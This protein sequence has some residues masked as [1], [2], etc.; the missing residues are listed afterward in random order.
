M[1]IALFLVL[2]RFCCQLSGV[3]ATSVAGSVLLARSWVFAK[4]KYWMVINLVILLLSLVT[5]ATANAIKPMITA[6]D[7]Y[8][9]ALSN[10]GG[11]KC[12]GLNYD[13]QLGDGTGLS[14]STALNVVGLTS[15][16]EAITTGS[17]HACALSVGGGVK[18]W[19]RGY[20]G[21]LGNNS[22]GVSLLPV[23]VTGLGSGVLAIAAGDAHTCALTTAGGV[24]CWGSNANG[25]LGDGSTAV[26]YVPVNVTGLTSG[27][28]AIATGLFHT[29]AL[30][31]TGGVKCWG[32]N[33]DG[34][35]GDGSTVNRL[36]PVNV[37]GLTSGVSTISA[38]QHTCAISSNGGAKCWG[39]NFH[40]N[41]GNGSTVGSLT[42]V[43]VTGMT[44]GVNAISTG[45]YSSCAV[46][47]SGSAKCWGLN[48]GGELGD[49][50]AI[51]RSTPVNVAGLT[52]GV[53]SIGLGHDHACALTSYG[54]VKCWGNNYL[55]QLGDGT[56][57]N[58]LTPVDVV[59]L[60]LNTI[61]PFGITLV[62][63]GASPLVTGSQGHLAPWVASMGD[64]VNARMGGSVPIIKLTVQKNALGQIVVSSD[65]TL[66]I[67]STN[68][69]AII[70]V[71]WST[72]SEPLCAN[73]SVQLRTSTGSVAN[74]LFQYFQSD[75]PSTLKLPWHMIGH[76]RGGSMVNA[77]ATA[78]STRGLWTN[79]VTFLDYH[80]VTGCPDY[81]P[82]V[83]GGVL[84]ADS[85]YE[86]YFSTFPNGSSVPGTF[87]K[88]LNGILPW[89]LTVVGFS[90]L[91]HTL[92][93]TY[94]HGTIDPFATGDGDGQSID[95]AWYS[96]SDRMLG[97][98]Y[99]REASQQSVS[100]VLAYPTEGLTEEISGGMGARIQSYA[101]VLALA[102]LPAVD[103]QDL[104]NNSAAVLSAF[105]PN[106]IIANSVISKSYTVGV[107]TYI[108]VTSQHRTGGYTLK[109]ELDD[110]LNPFNATAPGCTAVID[111]RTIAAS[112][113]SFRDTQIPWTPLAQNA[114][115]CFIRAT[116]TA[117]NSAGLERYSY[118]SQAITIRSAPV[119]SS[120]PSAPSVG[121]VVAGDGK[122]TVPFTANAIGT[123]SLIEYTAVCSS[124][125]FFNDWVY[126]TATT[127]PVVVE[128]LI[129]GT[130]YSCGVKTSSTAGVSE[131]SSVS[132]SVTPVGIPDLI[133]TSVTSPTTG[134]AGGFINVSVTFK[135]QGTA[136]AGSFFSRFLLST[137]ST[138]STSDI[139]TTYGC[140]VASLDV[141]LTNTC[142]GSIL[143][144][145]GTAGG[146]YYL[147]IYADWRGEVTESFENNN[148]RAAANTIV[149]TN[150]TPLSVTS[151]TLLPAIATV[152]T[153]YASTTPLT[154][155]GG[156]F[157]YTWTASGLPNGLQIDPTTSFIYGT[158]TVSGTFN[159]TIIATDSSNSPTTAAKLLSL[160][161]SGA[162][163]PIA[164]TI[165]FT[166]PGT[167]ALGTPSFALSASGGGS[168]NPVTFTSQSSGVCT[169]TS[170]GTVSLSTV[171]SCVIV[172]SQAGNA[173][174]LSASP[175]TQSFAVIAGTPV[176]SMSSTALPFSSQAVGT[177]GPAQ[178][179]TLTNTGNALL[180]LSS[181][182]RSGDFVLT[183]GCVSSLGVSASCD[184]SL[185]F[186]PTLMGT[187]YGTVSIY[188]NAVS[189]PNIVAFSAVGLAAPAPVC[190]LTAAPTSVR[191]NGSAKLTASCTPSP[192][193]YSWTGGTCLNT[194]TATCDVIP[195]VTTSYT[196]SGVNGVGA[197][198][199]ALFTLTVK[200]VDL[201]PIL[202]LLLD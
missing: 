113:F 30:M 187:R 1:N 178:V 126:G 39:N 16:V 154:A 87:E 185:Q 83:A 77:L 90:A 107:P 51:D 171:G 70:L 140:T 33:F 61:K 102:G 138:I 57:I 128:N 116:V 89:D 58:R 5:P 13:G 197:G 75:M 41:L 141:G 198:T 17:A 200:P 42:P 134:Q 166:N 150:T 142:S 93:H 55:G 162:V 84:F 153:A 191:K 139:A 50:T 80:S 28:T 122:V 193:T 43:N 10:S 179:V 4:G 34:E 98:G 169:V 38:G 25:N 65:K 165:Y 71:D 8:T 48:S 22:N 54:T 26:R 49:G 46:T 69:A 123:G 6:G 97:F 101:P 19:G 53:T 159:F 111:S 146:T 105:F 186:A 170:G 85:Y 95:P 202:M 163:G 103:T 29:C 104:S 2:R 96:G 130:T 184:L 99:S 45:F 147:G 7:G 173:S 176:L 72:L 74:A 47:I 32:S 164:Q 86:D 63:H 161:V 137:N 82:D 68:A 195:A 27:V 124:D 76:S 158:P 183:N 73:L 67:N 100:P 21:V 120:P 14:R 182:T 181:I 88:H 192:T 94:Y 18:C 115:S 127:S 143:I 64:A 177:I 131:W 160:S 144:P 157:P 156:Q 145:A 148:G 20:D 12:W 168:G 110:D 24:K 172:A 11:V 189:S 133:V 135:N 119:T 180:T 36:T 167:K 174:F 129:N 114:G 199:P 15:G 125:N 92:V 155:T 121:T 188:S 106:A 40:G 31:G 152:G 194:H 108:P 9:C 37:S 201:T 52:S 132:N 196:V 112:E 62:T 60:N 23:D 151:T 78:F 44:S 3:D 66:T 136:T 109:I 81:A 79:H 35:L 117:L 149:V 190:T 175:V 59:G 91:P 56:T 118:S